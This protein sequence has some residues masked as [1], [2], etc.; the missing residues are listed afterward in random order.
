MFLI[1]RFAAEQNHRAAT[2]IISFVKDTGLYR[3][4]EQP[5]KRKDVAQM[6]FK[7]FLSDESDRQVTAA[8]DFLKHLSRGEVRE[9]SSYFSNNAKMVAEDGAKVNGK[10]LIT[11]ALSKHGEL[12][13][14]VRSS[15]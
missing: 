2:K 12:F 1:T 9:A 11:D 5:E 10:S 3:S 7:R 15:S 8:E 6:V 4:L 13:S 14:K